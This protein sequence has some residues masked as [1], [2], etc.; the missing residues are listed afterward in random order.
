M[1]NG[2][3]MRKHIVSQGTAGSWC[4]FSCGNKEGGLEA[5]QAHLGNVS[6]ARPH[7]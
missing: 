3:E 6:R 4:G 7:T 5:V 1:D 2:V